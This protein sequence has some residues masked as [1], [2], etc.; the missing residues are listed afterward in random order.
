MHAYIA[1]RE[2]RTV[3]EVKRDSSDDPAPVVKFS[4]QAID[5]LICCCRF[6]PYCAASPRHVRVQSDHGLVTRQTMIA[7]I[8][9]AIRTPP[10]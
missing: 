5:G 4:G 6:T 7:A 1:M 10:R 3:G 8:V 9:S 2:G